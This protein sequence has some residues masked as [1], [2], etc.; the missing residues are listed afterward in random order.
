[1]P[2]TQ[3]ICSS[4][5]PEL[6][7]Y[8]I[9]TK[10]EGFHISS[11]TLGEREEEREGIRCKSPGFFGLEHEEASPGSAMCLLVWSGT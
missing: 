5:G 3:F 11:F 7:K 8:N 1:M 9:H 4:H 6:I 10:A 2:L